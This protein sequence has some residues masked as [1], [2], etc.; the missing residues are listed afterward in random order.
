MGNKNIMEEIDYYNSQPFTFQG[1]MDL[2][3]LT[4]ENLRLVC[5][6]KAEAIPD[7]GFVPS[8]EF[9]IY[10]DS[11]RVGDI[12]L[13]IGYHEG[14]YYS[15]HIDCV[16]NEA[17][18]GKGYAV[19]AIRLLAPVAQH[20]GME[21]LLI[22]SED[23]NMSSYRVCEKLGARFIRKTELPHWHDIYEEGHLYMNIF[24][25]DLRNYENRQNNARRNSTVQQPSV[26][27]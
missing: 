19:R 18:R 20:H 11:E 12:R 5:T 21:K 6:N 17:H 4:D 13:H 25:W 22:T 9:D 23:G 10:R 14:I 3:K 7:E 26:R 2:P 27:V 15:G 16:I 8:Y 24:E 1:F